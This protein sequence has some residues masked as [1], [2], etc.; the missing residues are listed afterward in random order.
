MEHLNQYSF[1]VKDNSLLKLILQKNNISK[2][3]INLFVNLKKLEFINLSNN[4]LKII[5]KSLFKHNTNLEV[6]NLSNNKI[7]YFN[8]ILDNFPK[9]S[10]VGLKHNH[11][12]T[13]KSEH[14]R[15]Y[16]NNESTIYSSTDRYINIGANEFNCNISMNWIPKLNKLIEI[17]IDTP[18]YCRKLIDNK[19]NCNITLGCYL[20][21]Q[22]SKV[23]GL[24]LSNC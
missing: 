23:C 19:K 16:V 20:G 21:I 5:Y 6:I 12:S 15:E 4:K 13:L 3:N 11:L 1:A 7:K 24:K 9:L 17:Q 18:T 14:F 8:L 10:H 2:L 22:F